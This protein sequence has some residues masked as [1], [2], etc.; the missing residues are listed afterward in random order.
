MRDELSQLDIMEWRA[1]L[2]L[3]PAGPIADFYRNGMLAALLFNANRSKE[4][5]P[6]TPKDY[7][8]PG[9]MDAAEE[10]DVSGDHVRE[11][12]MDIGRAFKAGASRP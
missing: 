11:V 3:E 5:A 1:Y 9:M 2:E 12:F 6:M 7:M 10:D 4:Q 8:P